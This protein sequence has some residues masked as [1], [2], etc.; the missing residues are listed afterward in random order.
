MNVAL[1]SDHT[2]YLGQ[3]MRLGEEHASVV[4]ALKQ[5]ANGYRAV[6][7]FV[8]ADKDRG[9]SFVQLADLAV[10]FLGSGVKSLLVQ[11][12]VG[13]LKLSD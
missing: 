5:I 7:I 4:K 2:K 11:P 6:G 1:T 3:V 13:H 9:C 10:E 8:V 12:L